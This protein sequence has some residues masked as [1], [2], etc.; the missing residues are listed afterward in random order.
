MEQILKSS[1]EQMPNCHSEAHG[2]DRCFA[3]DGREWTEIQIQKR[4]GG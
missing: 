3:N 2:S 1:L 4:E